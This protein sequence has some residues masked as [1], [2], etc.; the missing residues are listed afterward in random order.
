MIRGPSTNCTP[1]RSASE[2]VKISGSD[3]DAAGGIHRFPLPPRVPGALHAC[4]VDLIGPDP[5]WIVGS[6]GFDVVVCLMEAFEVEQRFPQYSAWL[7]ADDRAVHDPVPD[8]GVVDDRRAEALAWRVTDWLEDGL[9]VLLHC[10]GGYGRTG[11][12]AAQVL[13]ANGLPL[14]EALAEVDRARPGCGPQSDDQDAQLRRLV[15]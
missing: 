4:A 11:V 7:T 13:V 6:Y 12:I 3:L 8:Q 5:D 14:A 9:S 1:V 10:A 15:G 2:P